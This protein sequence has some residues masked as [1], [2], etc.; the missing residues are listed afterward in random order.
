M[1][2]FYWYDLDGLCGVVIVL[3]VVFY[4][5]FGWVFGGVDVFLVLFGFFFGGKIFCVVFN[6]DLLFLF[7]VEV[8]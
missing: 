3:V 4:V 2:G 1:I 8:I 5:W 7:I 6:L